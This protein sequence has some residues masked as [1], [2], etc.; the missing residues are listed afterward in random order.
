MLW[1]QVKREDGCEIAS[2]CICMPTDLSRHCYQIGHAGTDS[3]KLKEF[4]SREMRSRP[5][6]SAGTEKPHRQCWRH[7]K[8]A[9]LTFKCEILCAHSSESHWRESDTWNASSLTG[10]KRTF[11]PAHGTSPSSKLYL[12]TD[13][14]TTFSVGIRCWGSACRR[15]CSCIVPRK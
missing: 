12:D 3:R 14:V 7:S 13:S 8:Q 10:N 2:S 15:A 5:G 1:Q 6:S 9:V 11:T 4:R